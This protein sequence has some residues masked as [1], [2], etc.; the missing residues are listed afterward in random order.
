MDGDG[1]MEGKG[2]NCDEGMV[3]TDIMDEYCWA[4]YRF[5]VVGTADG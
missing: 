1:Y 2:V 5:R 4:I 3:M